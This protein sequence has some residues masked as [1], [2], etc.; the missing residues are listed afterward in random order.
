[1]AV[2]LPPR[3]RGGN[4]GQRR[5]RPFTISSMTSR[6]DTTDAMSPTLCPANGTNS[7][8]RPARTAATSSSAPSAG[9]PLCV[10]GVGRVRGAVT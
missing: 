1:M 7:S 2:V 10:K 5:R 3:R 9:G 4:G 6:T 8:P